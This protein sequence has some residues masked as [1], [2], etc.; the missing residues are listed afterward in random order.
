MSPWWTPHTKDELVTW[1]CFYW[2]HDRDRFGRMSKK[3][4]YAIYYRK[5]KELRPEAVLT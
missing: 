4:L 2:P 5:L 3:R 1:L